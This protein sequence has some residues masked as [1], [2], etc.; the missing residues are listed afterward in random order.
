MTTLQLGVYI[1][2]LFIIIVII[3]IISYFF[4]YFFESLIVPILSFLCF[5]GFMMAHCTAASL[6]MALAHF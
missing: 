5:I 4:I 1:Y 2:F 6:G 3:I